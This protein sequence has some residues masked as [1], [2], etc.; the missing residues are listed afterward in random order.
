MEMESEKGRYE[1]RNKYSD[2]LWRTVA[3]MVMEVASS[4]L[5][6]D[7]EVKLP[8]YAEA[9]I[10]HYWIFNLYDRHL[11]T[12]NPLDWLRVNLIT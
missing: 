8:L 12:S 5:D 6:Y 7:R 10:S 3:M 11:E 2:V 9:G 1:C 4:S